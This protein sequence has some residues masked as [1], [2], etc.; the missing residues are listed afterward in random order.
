MMEPKDC[1]HTYGYYH[2][3]L[4]SAD[5]YHELN[6][7]GFFIKFTYCPWC[8]VQLHTMDGKVLG[9][10]PDDIEDDCVKGGCAD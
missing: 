8:R 9:L 2:K 7:D 4:V 10:P 1:I 5:L 6:D 3:E